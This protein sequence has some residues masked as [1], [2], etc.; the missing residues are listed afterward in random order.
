MTGL[1]DRSE[2]RGGDAAA[3][4]VHRAVAIAPPLPPPSLLPL[5]SSFFF[6]MLGTLHRMHPSSYVVAPSSSRL[7]P[8]AP[9][10]SSSSLSSVAP[11][12]PSSSVQLSDTQCTGLAG[13]RRSA[14]RRRHNCRRR[15]RVAA[16]LLHLRLF[17]AVVSVRPP[18]SSWRHLSPPSRALLTFG[19]DQML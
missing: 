17:F 11:L 16:I 15:R 7:S 5:S 13:T 14:R 2:L 19:C 18:S 10:P 4:P 8:V 3:A 6:T 1:G 12:P 9:S